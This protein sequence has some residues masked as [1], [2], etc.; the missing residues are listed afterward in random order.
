[1]SILSE[2]VDYHL[3]Q[4]YSVA[5]QS[6]FGITGVLI[7]VL[8]YIVRQWRVIIIFFCMIPSILVLALLITYLE[9]TPKFLL[10]KGPFETLKAMNRIASINGAQ[11]HE[12]LEYEDLQKYISK[13]EEPKS[14]KIITPINLFMYGS[15]RTKT[16]CTSIIFFCITY[17]YIGPIVIVDKLGI[18]PFASQIIISA[19]EIIAYPLVYMIIDRTSRK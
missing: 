13:I 1:M 10:K 7:G 4:K 11:P 14:Q 16:I 5:L 3:R 15:L 12:L 2:V 8:F 19:S 9:E 17:V 18:D 6:S